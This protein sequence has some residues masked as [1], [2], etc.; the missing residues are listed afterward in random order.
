MMTV[1]MI[2]WKQFPLLFLLLTQ[3]PTSQ[4]KKQQSNALK[5]Y[6]K[7]TVRWVW[8]GG[9]VVGV[10]GVVDGGVSREVAG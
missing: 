2:T 1:I 5:T 7:T 3:K 6:I 9:G 10:G 8:G 4:L